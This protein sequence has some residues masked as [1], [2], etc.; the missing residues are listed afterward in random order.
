MFDLTQYTKAYAPSFTNSAKEI[1]FLENNQ[2]YPI[3]LKDEHL[4]VTLEGKNYSTDDNPIVFPYSQEWYDKLKIVYPNLEPYKDETKD[5][6][7]LLQQKVN[8]IACKI[9]KTSYQDALQHGYVCFKHKKSDD[10]FYYV[11]INPY[12]LKP[13]KTV[14]DYFTIP[15]NI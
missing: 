10:S 4:T 9:S 6:F 7:N 14:E 13:C 15:S 1:T 8:V 5:L 3:R 12:T 2:G 11:P